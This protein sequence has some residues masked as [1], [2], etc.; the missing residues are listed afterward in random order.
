[1][2]GF[3]ISILQQPNLSIETVNN[4][5][6]DKNTTEN[7]F[8]QV[9]SHLEKMINSTDFRVFGVHGIIMLFQLHKIS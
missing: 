1:M 4:N 9:K 7:D 3:N 8:K 2:T 5:G 6:N